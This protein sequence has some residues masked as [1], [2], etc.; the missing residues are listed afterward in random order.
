MIKS[1]RFKPS[2]GCGKLRSLQNTFFTSN[3]FLKSAI[4]SSEVMSRTRYY[5]MLICLRNKFKDFKHLTSAMCYGALPFS[6]DVESDKE[7]V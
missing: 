7:D 1:E 6:V 2:L 3:H 5:V 4:Q